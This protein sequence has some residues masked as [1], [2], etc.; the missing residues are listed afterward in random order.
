MRNLKAIIAYS[1]TDYFGWQKTRMGPSIEETLENALKQILQ[2]PLTLQA[3]SRTDRGV[4]AEGQ[5]INFLT[6][7]EIDLY[8][9]KRALSGLLPRTI[10]IRSL[11]EA[12]LPFHPTLDCCGKEYHYY[13]CNTPFQLPFL[14]H[15]SWHFHT[16]LDI[17]KMVEASAH[18]TGRHDFSAFTN[19]R[20]ED[21]IR[22]VERIDIHA[23]PGGRLRFEVEGPNFLYKMVRNIVGTLVYV[24]CQKLQPEELPR[25]LAE[26][27]R[28]LAGITAPAHG[29]FLN[30]V[31]YN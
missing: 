11:E 18:L 27:D 23:L 1:G 9:L 4:H 30:K 25:I 6:S 15:T 5:V 12:P 14:R 31:I 8:K 2:E 10:A 21:A 29:L 24:G 16:P 28:R 3:A 22:E 19:I 20:L 13:V 17:D 7:K 26:K